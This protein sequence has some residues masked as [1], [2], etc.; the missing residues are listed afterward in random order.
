MNTQLNH[1][2]AM[3]QHRERTRELER[4]HRHRLRTRHPRR[5]SSVLEPLS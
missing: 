4:E 3:D 2:L 1:A 5:G